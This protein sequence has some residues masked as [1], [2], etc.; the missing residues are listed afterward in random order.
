MNTTF[1]PLTTARNL[2]L[3][4]NMIRCGSEIYTWCYDLD[5][6]LVSTNCP[7]AAIWSTTFSM[8]GCVTT[9]LSRAKDGIPV[10]LGTAIG[11]YWTVAYEQRDDALVHCH[12]LGPVLFTEM[13]PAEVEYGLQQ[14]PNLEIS[15]AWKKQLLSL[16]PTL[17]VTQNLQLSHLALMLHYCIT[18]QK[19][20]ISDI[21]L[22]N[23]RPP[24]KVKE[25]QAGHNRH[26]VWHSEQAMLQMVRNGDLNYKSALNASIAS[27]SG[28]PIHG[29]DPLRQAKTSNIVFTTLVS[30][31]AIEGGLSP[32]EAY[33]LGDLYIQAV[34]NATSYSELSAN[35]ITMY[36]DYIH[37]VHDR[38]RRPILSKQIQTCC[39][40]ID[41]HLGEKL[42]ASDLAALV[43]YTEYYLTH[44][45]AKETGMSVTDYIN[46][47]RVDRAKILLLSTDDDIQS[48]AEQLSF[49]SRSYFSRVFS[50]LVGTTPVKYR[51][52]I[53]SAPS[54]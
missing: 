7:D 41:M 33:A 44:K 51:T 39:D 15:L 9:M 22:K 11:L 10:I 4:Q 50:E 1:D 52:G 26:G 45:F 6:Q 40:Y 5:G 20:L 13:T 8:L 34:E 43:G 27:S 54:S 29:K 23:L 18:G 47:A 25:G 12:V 30:R 19:L 38:K 3:F 49:G 16:L 28:V 37:R 14:Y 21:Y 31:A 53:C 46:R 32:E 2:E 35:A 17:P 48:I 36:D 42:H 24:K